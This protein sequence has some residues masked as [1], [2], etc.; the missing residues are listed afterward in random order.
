[1]KLWAALVCAFL[2][3][4]TQAAPVR[5]VVPSLPESRGNPHTYIGL[6]FGVIN[7][8]VFEP[9][10]RIGPGGVAEPVLAESWTQ[11]T[12]TRWAF[13]LRSGVRFSNGEPFD[14]AAVVAALN[15]VLG[16]PL[17]S[18]MLASVTMRA[19]IA[20]VSARDPLTVQIDTKVIDPILPVHLFNVQV[21]A[22]QAW[23]KGIAAFV[24]APVGTGPYRVTKWAPGSV[25]LAAN[26]SARTPGHVPEIEVR[27]MPDPI[28]RALAVASGSADVAMDVMAETATDGGFRLTPRLSTQVTFMQFVTVGNAPFKDVRVRRAL[29]YAV[30]RAKLIRI[31]LN[32]AVTPASQFT[33]PDAFGYNT[34]LAPY[35]YDP[36]KAKALLAEAGYPEGLTVPIEFVTGQGPDASIYQLVAADLAAVGVKVEFR[37][38]TMGVW[39][40]HLNSGAWP[41]GGFITGVQ[42]YD[43]VVAFNTRSCEWAKPF[44]CDRDVMPLLQAARAATTAEELRGRIQALM[45]YEHDN[46]PGLMLWQRTFFDGVG[47]RVTAYKVGRDRVDFAELR[48]K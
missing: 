48:A 38:V 13:K 44:H 42:G 2:T 25:M 28:A 43:P 14:A 21:P 16:T 4:A 5:I 20:A 18:D 47:P 31:F 32:D 29:N 46:P 12:P 39:L 33:H 7:Q 27:A 9:L 24:S 40:G 41:G 22:P 35:A 45:A 23:A 3:G 26:A 19:K 34:T 15:Y 6:P 30:D 8:A 17:P 37:P 1:M 36:A 11:E 10:V